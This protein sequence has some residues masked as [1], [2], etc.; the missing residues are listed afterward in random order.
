MLVFVLH[1]PLDGCEIQLEGGGMMGKNEWLRVVRV[2][3]DIF[4][5]MRMGSGIE[6]VFWVELRWRALLWVALV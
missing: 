2:H 6:G 4:T 5:V 1:V 3:G